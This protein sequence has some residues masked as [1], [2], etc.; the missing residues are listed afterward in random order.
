MRRHD[1]LPFGAELTSVGVRMRSV[2]VAYQV[3][4][5][6]AASVELMGDGSSQ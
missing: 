5:P 6:K 4:G 3:L 2:C 1:E